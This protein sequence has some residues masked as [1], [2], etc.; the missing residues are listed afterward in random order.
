MISL[1]FFFAAGKAFVDPALEEA[2]VQVDLFAGG[3]GLAEQGNRIPLFLALSLANRFQRGLE[4]FHVGDAG[5]FHRILEGQ[6]QARLGA[7]FGLQLCQ[8]LALKQGFAASDGVV[9]TTGKHVGQGRFAGAVGA[10][11]GVYLARFNG[12]V[13]AL[14]NRLVRHGG[15][16][17]TN[18]QHVLMRL[19]VG[20]ASSPVNQGVVG[21]M[22][23]WRRGRDGSPCKHGSY[24][25]VFRVWP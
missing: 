15:V 24:S 25:V 9:V 19:S 22:L 8:A 14:E 1:R 13:Q 20:L 21:A 5:D 23:A 6:E 18:F 16:Q 4:K 7:L 17:I 11:D 12:Q 2:G 3:T 10:H